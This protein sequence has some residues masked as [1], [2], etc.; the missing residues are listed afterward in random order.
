MSTVSSSFD[1]LAA[2]LIDHARAL[3]EARAS[4]RTL[5]ASDPALP[6]RRPGLVWPLF[7]KG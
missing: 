6:W 2:R 1:A 7:T 3:A 5:A 4:A